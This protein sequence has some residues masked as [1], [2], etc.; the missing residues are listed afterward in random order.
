[1][2]MVIIRKSNID[3]LIDDMWL[4]Q[5]CLEQS[6]LFVGLLQLSDNRSANGSGNKSVLFYKKSYGDSYSL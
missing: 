6:V 2:V 3:C 1:M 4:V 5:A